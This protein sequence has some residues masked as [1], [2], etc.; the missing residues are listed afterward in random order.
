VAAFFIFFNIN[1]IMKKPNVLLMFSGGLDS[2]GAFWKLLQEKEK[3]HVHHLY[4]VNKENR[5]LAEDK[6]VKDIIDYMKKIG[7][8]SYSESYHEYP[9]YNGNF[10]WDS[11]MYNFIA[12]TICLSIKSIKEVAIGRT[13]SDT[14]VDLR[15]ERGTKILNA[16][17]PNIK[18]IYPVGDMTKKEIYKMLPEDLRNITWSC[19]RPTYD[20]ETKACNR[21][22]TCMEMN[23]IKECEK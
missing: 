22:K 5:A 19:R 11:D 18:K 7:D 8:F 17:D 9:S 16:F 6:A 3:I 21:C 12:G 23:K 4:L 10:M 1:I 13:K 2:T 14:G 20:Q 15:A